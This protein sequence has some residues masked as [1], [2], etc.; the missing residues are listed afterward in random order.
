LW[1]ERQVLLRSGTPLRLDHLERVAFRDA[2]VLILP[3]ADFGERRPETVDA[4]T[5]KTLLAV[6]QHARHAGD[7]P[8]LAVAELYD[9]RRALVARE[10]YDGESEILATDEIISQIIAES[11]RQ[12]GLCGVF[13]ELLTINLG[14]AL[15]VRRVEGLAGARFG[16]IRGAFPRAVVIG[17]VPSGG[18]WPNLNPALE[19]VV[20]NGDL[21]V[22]VARSFADCEPADGSRSSAPAPPPEARDPVSRSRHVLILGWSRKVPALLEDF[23][24]YGEDAF[25]IDVVSATPIADRES[26]LARHGSGGA[27]GRIRQIEAGYTAP[28]VLERLEPQRY[29]NIVL[30]AS[31]RLDEEE[32]ADATTAFAYLMLRRLLEK[33]DGRPAIFVELL[34]EENRFLFDGELEDVIVSPLLVSYLLSQ[35]ALRRELASVFAELAR[36]KGAHLVLEP[37]EAYLATSGPVRFEELERAASARGEIALGLRR[38]GSDDGLVLNPDRDAEWM[39]GSGDQLVLLRSGDEPEGAGPALRP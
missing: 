29:D 21:L 6:S 22:F 16:E 19:T 13:T 1:S 18:G 17:T 37:A 30:L 27:N 32:Q 39:L 5:V 11:V 28:G 24:G 23:A 34:D 25:E 14:C 8:P 31:E 10:A 7:A 12:G 36:P 35:V 33:E 3:G 2:A 9:G 15:Y 20:T 4:Q 26:A 38:N